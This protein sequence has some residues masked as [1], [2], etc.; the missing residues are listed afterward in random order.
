MA[1]TK[2]YRVSVAM[3]IRNCAS[4]LPESIDSLLAQTYQD[5]ELIMCDDASTDNTLDVALSYSAKYDNIR[6]IKNEVNL[7]LAASL[8]RCIELASPEAE[9]IARQDGDDISEPER[10]E[11]QVRFLDQHPEYVLVSTAMTN[12]DETGIWGIQRK[13]EFPTVQDFIKISPFCHAPV[14]MR[15]KELAE[16][17][18]YTVS[19]YLRR[20]QDYWLWHKFYIAGYKGCNLQTAYYRMRDDRAATSRRK[21]IDRLYGSKVHYQVMKNLKLPV[22]NYIWALR[23]V[24]VGLLPKF[25]YDRLHRRNINYHNHGSEYVS[26]QILNEVR[27]LVSVIIPIYNAEKYLMQCLDSIVGQS[28][29]NLQIICVNDG[30]TDNSGQIMSQ[31]SQKD[32]RIIIINQINGGLSSARN[33]GLDIATGNWIMFVDSDDWINKET[34]DHCI[35]EAVNKEVDIVTFDYICEYVKHSERRKYMSKEHKFSNKEYFIRLLG[36]IGKQL[37]N[38]EKV[39]AL[40]IACAKLYRKEIINGTRFTDHSIIGP[41]EDTLFNLKVAKNYTSAIYSP[42]A[43]YHY[44]KTN[45]SAIT[46]RYKPELI[47]KWDNLFAE[48][49]KLVDF[50]DE[51][52]TTAYYNRIACSLIGAGI[53][54]MRNSSSFKQKRNRIKCILS[55]P[56]YSE[57]L[58]R[59]NLNDIKS[60]KWK[61]FFCSAKNRHYTI[62]T[63]ILYAIKEILRRKS[64]S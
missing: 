59:L 44:R 7:G 40:S 64:Q 1:S 39:D 5:W 13:P 22:I 11:V 60:Y 52:E 23:G 62:S 46:Q 3:G 16:V 61:L 26:H 41:S 34:V 20:G 2:N 47:E 55:K 9:F 18:N 57:A 4:T 28:Y 37:S 10:F 53:N 56:L 51:I 17:G 30:S 21:F 33:T 50:N 45:S 25:V 29:E 43:G 27:P 49:S 42:F 19:K 14:M 6:V 31:Y 12:F 36:P 54:E 48:I 35:S 38:P 63:L 24:I 8:N 58:K 32:N 15:R